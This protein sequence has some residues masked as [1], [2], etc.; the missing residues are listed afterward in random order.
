MKNI[1]SNKVI[2]RM[3]SIGVE[4]ED[5]NDE[6]WMLF[7]HEG[8]QLQ[9]RWVHTE[10]YSDKRIRLVSPSGQNYWHQKP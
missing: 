1:T 6:A 2:R 7:I 4:L 3:E 10:N 8:W 5:L 9:V